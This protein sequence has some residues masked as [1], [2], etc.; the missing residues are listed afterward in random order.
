MIKRHLVT[1]CY[2]KARA[3]TGPP[4]LRSC[5][6]T[7]STRTTT[8]TATATAPHPL[9]VLL[10]ALLFVIILLALVLVV[11]VG[12]LVVLLL[13]LVLALLLSAGAVARYDNNYGTD[14]T[15]TPDLND[16]DMRWNGA[17]FSGILLLETV[18]G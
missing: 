10:L 1:L 15:S 18:T 13:V 6:R 4:R 12:L 5:T 16:E 8:G 14:N 3:K 2:R 17:C 9:L 11:L 7:P